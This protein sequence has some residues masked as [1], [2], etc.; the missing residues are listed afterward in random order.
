MFSS[1]ISLKST[2]LAETVTQDT[3]DSCITQDEVTAAQKTWGEGI[4]VIANAYQSD[5][6]G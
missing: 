5:A 1:I 4:V 6:F 3:A 2:S